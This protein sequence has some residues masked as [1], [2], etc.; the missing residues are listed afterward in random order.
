M[1]RFDFERAVEDSALPRGA[2]DVL[3]A[4]ARRLNAERGV[5]LPQHTP[6]ITDL[7]HATAMSRS[8]ICYSLRM[9]ELAGWLT[10][11]RPPLREQRRRHAR[12]LY[13]LHDPAAGP[14]APPKPGP[15]ADSNGQLAAAVLE[16]MTTAGRP[17]TPGQAAEIARQVLAGRQVRPGKRE[18]YV[19]TAIRADPRKYAPPAA[20]LPPPP[21][22]ETSPAPPSEEARQLLTTIRR[23]RT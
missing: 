19:R 4:L 15:A 13:L 3:F 6:S 22:P 5:I 9:A 7:Q 18:I 11:R 23:R 10:R 17:V 16:E 1:N 21:R 12:T 14:A 20:G 2:R 8:G